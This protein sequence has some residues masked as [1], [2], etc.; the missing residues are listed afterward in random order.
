METLLLPMLA[1]ISTD[2]LLHALIWLVIMGLVFWVCWWALNTINPP[3][4]FKKVGT[5]LLVLIAALLIINL[6]LGLVGHPLF[7]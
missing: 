1:V 2:S 7:N 4:P 3:E 5:V 6:L